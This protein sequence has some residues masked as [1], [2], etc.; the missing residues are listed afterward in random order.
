[1]PH[2]FERRHRTTGSGR[3]CREPSSEVSPMKVPTLLLLAGALTGWT[4]PVC[5]ERE[6]A[7]DRL[8]QAEEAR[9][10]DREYWT[11][12]TPNAAELAA[13]RKVERPGG[14]SVGLLRFYL[15]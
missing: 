15:N 4:C 3:R 6:V 2:S 11:A 9:R 1:M 5:A 8:V 13:F 12:T 14:R 7:T 10:A